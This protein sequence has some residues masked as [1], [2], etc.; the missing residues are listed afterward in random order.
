MPW[1]TVAQSLAGGA[2]LILSS[3]TDAFGLVFR[4]L[5]FVA[6]VFA[7]LTLLEIQRS[8]D[9]FDRLVIP[10]ALVSAAFVVLGTFT[11]VSGLVF[12]S[13]SA[14]DDL[15]F[16]RTLNALG[17]LIYLVCATVT[18]LFFTSVSPVGVHTA[19][20]WPQFTVTATDRLERARAVGETSDRKS[21][22]LN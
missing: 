12:P 6:A 4:A 1:I 8:A 16:I 15:V 17:M 19:A 18:L 13:S 3:G 10:L 5:F 9:R 2:V 14:G 7:G 11:L 22:R 20:S 21:T